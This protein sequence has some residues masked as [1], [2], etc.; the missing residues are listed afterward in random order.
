MINTLTPITLSQFLP[1]KTRHHAA[2]PLLA[3][4]S[5]AGVMEGDV[6]IEVDTFVGGSHG[7]LFSLEGGGL[8]GWHFGLGSIRCFNGIV[9]E[10][11]R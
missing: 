1:D 2:D 10:V 6:V 8:G 11:S 3:D 4:N 5:V 7:G 9:D